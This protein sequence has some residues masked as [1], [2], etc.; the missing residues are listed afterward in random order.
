MYCIAVHRPDA[1]YLVISLLNLIW[2]I[3]QAL[4]DLNHFDEANTYYLIESNNMYC[5]LVEIEM[6]FRL[7]L[8]CTRGKEIGIVYEH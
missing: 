7:C 3:M 5:F 2:R 1:F 6:L 4:T 8:R